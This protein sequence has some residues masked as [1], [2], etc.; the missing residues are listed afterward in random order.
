MKVICLTNAKGGVGKST[1]AI[2]VAA[3]L[4]LRD[5]RVL[6]IDAD[7]QGCCA[8]QLGVPESSGFYRLL[9]RGAAWDEV[10][11][12]PEAGRWSGRLPTVGTLHLLPGDT[13]TARVYKAL[14]QYPL[15]LRERLAEVSGRFDVAIIDTPPSP[16]LLH[17]ILFFATDAAI[18]VTKCARLSLRGLAQSTEY[19]KAHD[20]ERERY[21]LPPVKLLGVLP[22]LWRNTNSHYRGRELLERWGGNRR[23]W[24]SSPLRTIWEDRENAQQTMY[25]YAPRHE[26]IDEINAVVERVEKYVR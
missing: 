3:G 21:G 23:I 15:A 11:R 19:M 6:L 13:D 24:E 1:W 5:K 2:H 18:Y 26:V 20:V 9:A 14:E 10:L 8:D 4:A 17:P 12:E 7:A 22:T 16:S 25:A